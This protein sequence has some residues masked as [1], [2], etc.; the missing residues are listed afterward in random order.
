MLPPQLGQGSGP[1]A[2]AAI[3]A[4]NHVSPCWPTQLHSI[5]NASGDPESENRGERREH[6]DLEQAVQRHGD[7]QPPVLPMAAQRLRHVIKLLSFHTRSTSFPRI[8]V[9]HGSAVARSR[10]R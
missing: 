3:S 9:S 7:M 5:P 8:G 2:A 6:D 1:I 4:T 10:C